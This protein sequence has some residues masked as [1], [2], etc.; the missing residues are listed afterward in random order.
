LLKSIIV[1]ST[2]ISL[3]SLIIVMI[4][5]YIAWKPHHRHDRQ[6]YRIKALSSPWS[7]GIL[8]QSLK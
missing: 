8:L 7:T 3:E 4:D 1:I 2:N 5:K 6:I